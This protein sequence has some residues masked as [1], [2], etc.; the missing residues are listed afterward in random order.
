MTAEGSDKLREAIWDRWLAVAAGQF[1]LAGLILLG[2]IGLM[3]LTLW[4]A[5]AADGFDIKQLLLDDAGRVSFLK[6]A[7]I[8]AFGF[9]SWVLMKDTLSANGANLW[10]FISYGIIWSG[11]PIAHDLVE[12]LKCKWTAEK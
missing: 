4:R 5:A 10:I 8:G 12:A 2:I 6:T 3:V 7:T 11:A 1:D 9:H